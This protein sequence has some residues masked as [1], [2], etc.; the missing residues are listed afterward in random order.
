MKK[1]ILCPRCKIKNKEK[2]GYCTD[3]RKEWRKLN[4]I[5]NK[6]RD[7]KKSQEWFKNNPEKRKLYSKK[8]RIKARLEALK[9][10]SNGNIK[11]SCPK[12][13]VD[14]IEFLAIDHINNDGAEKRR[15]GVEPK[16]G[17]S[18]YI[19]LR[20]NKYPP[21]FQVLCH[22]CNMAKQHNGGVC[23]HLTEK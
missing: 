8:V 22:N 3:C 21:G 19:Y 11:C 18:F 9:Y 14:K 17:T 10:Y 12:C 13:N 4:Y 7:Y 2:N 6:D 15:L 20:K 23:P 5:K 16:G 1:T